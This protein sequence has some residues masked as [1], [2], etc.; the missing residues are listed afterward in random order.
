M[1][2]SHPIYR[3][4]DGNADGVAEVLTNITVIQGDMNVYVAINVY[5]IKYV[6]EEGRVLYNEDVIV[7]ATVSEYKGETPAKGGHDCDD[8][9]G[10]G[11]GH[12]NCDCNSDWDDG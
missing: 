7:G 12:N 5:T 9:N 8:K 3:F 11:K 1:N 10:K 2:F 6:T 4:K